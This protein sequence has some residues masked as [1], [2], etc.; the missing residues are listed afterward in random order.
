L[1]D[2]SPSTDA[3][4]LDS[5]TPDAPDSAATEAA[6]CPIPGQVRTSPDGGC[7]CPPATYSA[8]DDVSKWT[9]FDLSTTADGGVV[10]YI[11]GA[12]DT[13]YVHFAND[14]HTRYDTT[15][16]FAAAG[17]WSSLPSF[18]NSTNT[19]R[20]AFDGRY[21]YFPPYWGD[22]YVGTIVRYD[23]Q[24]TFT[25]QAS[26]T[27]FDLSTVNVGAVGFQGAVFDGRYLYLVPSENGA[28]YFG[29][30]FDGVVARYD[31]TAAF[32]SSSSWA[33]FDISTVNAAAKGFRGGAFDGRY[34]Y[35]V[36][37]PGLFI[38]YTTN[39]N[40]FVSRYDSRSDFLNAASWSTFDLA[41]VNPGAT[42]LAGG[43]F[44]GAAF[45]G[46]YVYLV[47]FVNGTSAYSV[48]MRYDSASSFA[49]PTSW[50]TFDVSALNAGAKGFQ[51]AAFDGR[52]VY[53]APS[54][55]QFVTPFGIYSVITRYDTTAP[56]GSSA[57]WSAF[58]LTTLS[59][60]AKGFSGAVFDGRSVYLVPLANFLS[61]NGS[62]GLVVRFDAKSPAC[63]PTGWNASFF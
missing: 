33:T 62:D 31:T 48:V 9:T 49:D 4:L 58:D 25:S 61:P 60:G 46:R 54:L 44:A 52:Y 41:K 21:V 22:R 36:P 5:F 12:F 24:S 26:W 34:V 7:A 17:S 37:G 57:S 14:W 50:T 8:L 2:S 63:L 40:T 42:G 15:K 29:P 13:R 6:A 32:A 18:P 35:L 56:F 28:N 11:G 45:D 27:T 43:A 47:P 51:G 19:E 55:N 3:T 59:P 10:G 53:L 20:A 30:S 1:R 23:S 16:D 38:E 39:P